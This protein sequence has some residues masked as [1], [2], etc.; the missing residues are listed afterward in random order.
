MIE[1]KWS[2]IPIKAK[3]IKTGEVLEG[4][5]DGHGHFDVP[6]DHHIFD[7]YGLSEITD[8]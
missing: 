6:I 7:R 3:V 8:N 2:N 5:T 1:D 4:F